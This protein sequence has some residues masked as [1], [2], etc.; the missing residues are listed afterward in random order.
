MLYG[1]NVGPIVDGEKPIGIQMQKDVAITVIKTIVT[2]T[3]SKCHGRKEK[4]RKKF[5]Y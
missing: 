3:E 5:L 1:I 2:S 4:R